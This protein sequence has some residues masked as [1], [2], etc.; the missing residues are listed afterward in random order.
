MTT[1]DQTGVTPLNVDLGD[2]PE[3][4]IEASAGTGKTYSLTTLVARLVVEQHAEI[5]DLLVV[6]FT[7]AAAGELRDRIRATLRDALRWACHEDPKPEPQA[8]SLLDRWR[9]LGIADADAAR[10]LDQALLDLDRANVMTI[11]GFCQRLLADFAFDGGL[12]FAF[13]IAGDGFDTL[14]AAVRDQWRRSVYS[15]PGLRVR[16]AQ[17]K[18]FGPDKLVDW[19]ARYVAKPGLEVHG[20]EPP[21]HERSREL[22]DL[23]RSWHGALRAARNALH[24]ERDDMNDDQ[25]SRIG[26][27]LRRPEVAFV[28]GANYFGTKA[29]RSGLL[30]ANSAST[31]VASLDELGRVSS[32][33]RPAYDEALRFMR[34]DALEKTGVTLERRVREDRRLGYDDILTGAH[35]ALRRAGGEGL[36]SR[37]RQRYPWA[38]IDEYQDTDRVQADIFRRI[39]RDT[40]RVDEPG[41]LPSSV[42]RSSRSTGSAAPTYSPT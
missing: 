1:L 36:A 8:G 25:R 12:P 23:E 4:L 22:E 14:S 2:A 41:D 26:K 33:L 42:I 34:R 17:K 20:G 7:V 11:H 29:V 24:A 35:E 28:N 30:R 39:Y 15:A 21:T 31:L 10:L 16:Y 40:W 18:E 19:V 38:L 32:E 3:L 5:G 13:E 37:I 6:T 9:S 27:F